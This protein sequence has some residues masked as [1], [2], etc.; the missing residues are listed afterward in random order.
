MLFAGVLVNGQVVKPNE[1]NSSPSQI[2]AIKG[3]SIWL[4]WNYTYIG[5]GTHGGGVIITNY[6]K[7]IIGF[8]RISQPTIQA[9]AKRTGQNGVL[10]S[11]SP[12]PVPFNGRIE[13]ISSNSTLVINDLQYNDSLYQFSSNIKITQN[14][15]SGPKLEKYNL[16]PIVAI[17]VNGIKF[18]DFLL[19][20][21]GF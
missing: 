11:E 15:G 5:D 17:T 19:Y 20:C 18:C 13:V 10:T 7:Q 8:N 9:L 2:T 12:M 6:T 4:H 21:N 3:S 16:K 14:T 1:A